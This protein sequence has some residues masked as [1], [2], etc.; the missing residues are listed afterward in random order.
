[1][2]RKS[3][4][5][6]KTFFASF[7]SFNKKKKRAKRRTSK[8]MRLAEKRKQIRKI[9]FI[10]TGIVLF[11]LFWGVVRLSY[12]DVAR[13]QHIS[14]IGVE[15][16]SSQKLSM[17]AWNALQDTRWGIFS[18]RN[19]LLYD[20]SSI[21]EKLLKKYPRIKRL[22]V[23]TSIPKKEIILTVQEYQEYAQ[24]CRTED[25]CYFLTKDGYIFDTVHT[26]NLAFVRIFGGNE[27]KQP[28]RTT[29]LPRF[30]SS[31]TQ[32]LEALRD[33]VHLSITK[34][35]LKERDGFFY[36]KDGW[37]VKIPLD[38]PI[39]I[40]LLNL[41]TLLGTK[42]IKDHKDVLEYIDIRFGNRTYYKLRSSE[43]DDYE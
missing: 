23:K 31:L 24:W 4:K 2:Y 28:L 3:K 16:L 12:I 6:K 43:G 21:K 30:F 38:A 26:K 14:V 33:D 18:G 39:D 15:K 13:I 1:M 42:E 5:K 25:K 17:D 8:K 29:V 20:A 34:V 7:F 22:I 9:L 41:Q 40:T 36:T 27:V 35:T 11:A 32:L 37:F 10:L 19:I